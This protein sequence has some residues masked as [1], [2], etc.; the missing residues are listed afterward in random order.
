MLKVLAR[1]CNIL[2]QARRSSSVP[3]VKLHSG[4]EVATAKQIR[5]ALSDSGFLYVSNHGIPATQIQHVFSASRQFFELPLE[6]KMKCQVDQNGRGYT[7]PYCETL[8]PELQ[9]MGD[10]KEGFYIG[11][12]V[13]AGSQESRLPLHGANNWPSE[14]VL[15][16]WRALMYDYHQQLTKLSLYLTELFALS[17]DL[18]RNYFK[19]T[20]TH[21]VAV[22]RLLR[23]FETRSDLP[24]GIY[25]SGPHSDYGFITLLMTDDQPGLQIEVE[26]DK[27]LDVP[28]V[29][30]PNGERPF[31]VNIGDLL[32]RWSN[33]E[34]KSTVHRVVNMTGKERYSVPFFFEPNFN[35]LV[36]CIPSCT[37][38]TRPAL[39]P[40]VISGEYLLNMYDKTQSF[41]EYHNTHK[42]KIMKKILTCCKKK[43]K[44]KGK[45]KKH[46]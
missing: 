22:L 46:V 35:T 39:Y 21:P 41:S 5:K 45:K 34:F 11:R 10:T 4:D 26:K 3:I 27:W 6:E 42:K 29:V 43:K 25:A 40:P 9:T 31:V 17:L 18:D 36:E 16:G 28:P 8:A 1:R 15:P 13:V 19:P 20:F 23:Y 7:V 33:D 44:T 12:E 2:H 38:P 24:K 37:S 30:L 32:A 14:A